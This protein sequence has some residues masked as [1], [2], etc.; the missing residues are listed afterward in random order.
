MQGWGKAAPANAGG[1]GVVVEIGL[2]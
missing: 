1:D 2:A